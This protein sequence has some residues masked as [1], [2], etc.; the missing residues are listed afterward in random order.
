M[1]AIFKLAKAD[2]CQFFVVLGMCLSWYVGFGAFVGPLNQWVISRTCEQLEP[3]GIPCGERDDV[4]ASSSQLFSLIFLA[5]GVPNALT[6]SL[7]GELSDAWGR[8]FS[9]IIGLIGAMGTVGCLLVPPS[10]GNAGM[11]LIMALCNFTG[12]QFGITGA[13]FAAVGD[14]AGAA[15]LPVS[16]SGALLGYLACAL[17]VGLV[18]GPLIGG[19]LLKY[20]PAWVNPI[21]VLACYCVTFVLVLVCYRET[22]SPVRVMPCAARLRCACC[23]RVLRD[24]DPESRCWSG[25][26]VVVEEEEEEEEKDI[27]EEEATK[28]DAAA[29]VED[30]NGARDA[31]GESEEAE[32]GGEMVPAAA[33]D[34]ASSAAAA[35]AAEKATPSATKD[36]DE[37]SAPPPVAAH[38]VETPTA[39]VIEIEIETAVPCPTCGVPC[40]DA[41]LKLLLR[42]N[43]IGG[44]LELL[45]RA[46]SALV[47]LMLFVSFTATVAQI[48][49]IPF[50]LLQELQLDAVYV[51][52]WQAALWGSVGFGNLVL[53]EPQIRLLG[54][55]RS[56]ILALV[57]ASICL[58]LHIIAS[59]EKPWA[60]LILASL[61]CFT[62]GFDAIG[63]NY[64]LQIV[65]VE[66]LG[67]ANAGWVTTQTVCQI[68]GPL[69]AGVMY[70]TL[71][72]WCFHVAG[73]FAS[74]SS[75]LF[76][77]FVPSEPTVNM[78]DV[79]CC[80]TPEDRCHK[81]CSRCCHRWWF[82]GD[83]GAHAAEGPDRAKTSAIA[84]AVILLGGALGIA[85]WL[86][87][88]FLLP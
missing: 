82:S 58:P 81:G 33:E 74:L 76:M 86:L 41:S 17:N 65:G 87:S 46:K 70:N 77:A 67:L 78:P 68:V 48:V 59:K 13:W 3:S 80:R 16:D 15:G 60:V 88:I 47:L 55:K 34:A 27:G 72:T 43:P 63:R 19:A 30:A 52:L 28:R 53:I 2:T 38:A 45:M 31:E 79:F 29:M 50:I 83:T 62:F 37:A 61:N 54:S 20:A 6:I 23:A 64:V 57:F 5:I 1:N 18:V 75:I 7:F 56:I 66:K 69:L 85:A 11:L 71:P 9:I 49:T 14:L 73:S 25:T 12:G 22:L 4:K 44:I 84:T 36:G 35:P 8:Q 32:G 21:F 10:A 42:I 51:G 24:T 40:C 26:V 39:T